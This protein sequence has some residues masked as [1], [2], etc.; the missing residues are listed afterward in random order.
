MRLADLAEEGGHVRAD[1]FF[2][3]EAVGDAVE[4]VADADDPRSD[5]APTGRL[6]AEPKRTRM[7]LELRRRGSTLW[8]FTA[9]QMSAREVRG[10][11]PR[12]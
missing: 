4:L 9:R 10:T 3:D 11:G 7:D 12:R 1:P 2:R 5:P 8:P 6:A